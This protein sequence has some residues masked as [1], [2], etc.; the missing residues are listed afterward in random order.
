MLRPFR[1][2]RAGS[3]GSRSGWHVRFTPKATVGHQDA[4]PLLSAN[5]DLTRRSKKHRYSITSSVR[6]SSETGTS[7]PS[8]FAVLTLM[9]SSNLSANCTG[10]L[11][12]I[13]PFSTRST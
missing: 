9:I 13:S 12:G 10:K 8:V 7:R 1:V 3:R 5:S 2:S 6:A 11:A 4:N